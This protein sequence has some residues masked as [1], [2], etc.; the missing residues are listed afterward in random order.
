MYLDTPLYGRY[1][2]TDIDI[3]SAKLSSSE[4]LELCGPDTEMIPDFPDGR[5]IYAIGNAGIVKGRH[6]VNSVVQ[7]HAFGDAN[8]VAALRLVADRF[9]WIPVPKVLFQGV[10][11]S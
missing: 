3:D 11:K 9:P 1:K 10:V 4:T 8:E 2:S 6:E 7:S 5:R